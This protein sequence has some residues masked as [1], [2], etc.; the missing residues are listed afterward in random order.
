MSESQSAK[1]AMY[2]M[3]SPPGTFFF[4]L[5]CVDIFTMRTFYDF[6]NTGFNKACRNINA[7]RCVD[8]VFRDLVC[9]F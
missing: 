8:G 6:I 7:A 1:L 2:L 5:V 4:V 9:I 3:S